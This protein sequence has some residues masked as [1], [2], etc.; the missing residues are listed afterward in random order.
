MCLLIIA[1]EKELAK[2]LKEGQ[3]LEKQI[4]E[5]VRVGEEERKED[6]CVGVITASWERVTKLTTSFD[7]LPSFSPPT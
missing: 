4:K 6:R 5:E 2:G 3:E 1:N 7:P